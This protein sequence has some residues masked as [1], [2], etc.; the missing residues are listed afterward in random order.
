MPSLTA[1]AATSYDFIV[2]GMCYKIL[3]EED[4]TVGFVR[5]EIGQEAFGDIQIPETVW[6]G[7]I[8]YTVNAINIG[9]FYEHSKVTSVVMPNSITEV[10]YINVFDGSIE[11]AGI[12]VFN[13]IF[14]YCSSLRKVT[15]SEKLSEI[16]SHMFVGCSSLDNIELPEGVISIGEGAFYDCSSLENVEFPVGLTSIGNSAFLYCIYNHRTTKTNQKYPSVNL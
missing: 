10:I 7:D 14:G 2:D 13:A 11:V 1:T 12:D 3:S 4:C 15:L 9:A 6:Y 16:G 5:C 8:A